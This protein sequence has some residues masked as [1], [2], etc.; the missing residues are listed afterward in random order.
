MDIVTLYIVLFY[1]LG[2]TEALISESY[3]FA[4]A[5]TLLMLSAVINS[6]SIFIMY[7]KPKWNR[8]V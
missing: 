4:I 3:A 7:G 2:G 1:S 5:L 6:L 8:S